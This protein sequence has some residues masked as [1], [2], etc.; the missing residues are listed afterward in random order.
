MQILTLV[1]I[2]KN[3]NPAANAIWHECC[4]KQD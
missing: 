3:R 2:A 1:L 4:D